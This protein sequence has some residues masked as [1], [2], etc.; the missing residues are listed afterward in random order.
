MPDSPARILV[1]DDE[2]DVHYSFRRILEGRHGQVICAASGEEALRHVND[3][4]PDLVFMDIHMPGLSGLETMRHMRGMGCRAPVII[5]TAYGTPQH[6]IEAIKAGAFDYLTKPFDVPQLERLIGEAL[7]FSRSLRS[8]VALADDAAPPDA[9]AI[10]GSSAL[11]QAVFKAIGRVAGTDTTV[12]ITGES[13][14][15][16][17]LV[18]R[19]IV[20]HS[21]RFKGPFL[22]VNCAALPSN[23][24]ESELFGHERG[25]FTGAVTRQLGR[26]ERCQHG[27]L[28]LDEI[29]ELPIET[30]SKLLRA[31]EE[32]Q[33]ERLGGAQPIQ[34]DVRLIAATN[35][36]LEAA[37]RDGR[38]REDLFYRLNVFRIDLP[39]LRQRVE[40][41]APLAEFFV[42]RMR[43][44]G[45][46][47]LRHIEPEA[48]ELLRAQPWPGNV[49][50]LENLIER[51]AISCPSEVAGRD[52][53]AG[54]LP[55]ASAAPAAAPAPACPPAEPPPRIP[56]SFEA[57]L[58]IL[59]EAARADRN[60]ALI[61]AAERHL[62]VR[63]LELTA[64]NQVQTAKLLGITRATLRKRIAKYAIRLQLRVR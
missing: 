61:A 6:A 12:L 64:G 45:V 13:G 19:A 62:I 24:L 31:I 22:A 51:L 54:V 29:A 50:E 7:R 43:A 53:V 35:R 1:V 2:S 47:Q 40:D 3:A 30:Q 28:F 49:R 16:K 17:E 39:P 32:G 11:M 15:G 59:F 58:A 20:Q 52:Q 4:E 9:D 42:K 41:V 36:N 38:F 8:R 57:A 26:F 46:G 33:I 21:R 5:T 14:T 10:I 55:G 44:R 34:V 48:I 25:A 27:T 56:D 63:A 60:L 18:A 37:V 23:L